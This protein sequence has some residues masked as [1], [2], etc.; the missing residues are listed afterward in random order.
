MVACVLDRFL[1]R[2]VRL[3]RFCEF[4]IIA[5]GDRVAASVFGTNDTAS[6][7]RHSAFSSSSYHRHGGGG[8]RDLA[9]AD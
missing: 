3:R 9:E 5:Q 6:A 1:K 7:G 2:G 8:E 4:P